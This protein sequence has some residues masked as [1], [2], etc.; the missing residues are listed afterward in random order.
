MD[1]IKCH[2]ITLRNDWHNEALHKLILLS[3]V[4]SSHHVVICNFVMLIRAK[5]LT[6]LLSNVHFRRG[7]EVNGRRG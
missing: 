3:L 6:A 5:I 2:L 4:G 1:V 7:G